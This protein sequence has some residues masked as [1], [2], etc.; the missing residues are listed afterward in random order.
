[1]EEI[2]SLKTE[3]HVG[4]SQYSMR[5][6]TACFQRFRRCVTALKPIS[7]SALSPSRFYIEM[8]ESQ[9]DG[10]LHLQHKPTRAQ[11]KSGTYTIGQ[12]TD[13]ERQ[14]SDRGAYQT[15][16][17]MRPIEQNGG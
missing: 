16:V 15:T 11:E 3:S 10:I 8:S 9:H 5:A 13:Q 12:T 2:T 6:N 7:A 17:V 14:A 4:F 1:M